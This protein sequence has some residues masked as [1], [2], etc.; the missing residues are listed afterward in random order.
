MSSRPYKTPPIRCRAPCITRGLSTAWRIGRPPSI[1]CP[2]HRLPHIFAAQVGP[3]AAA[4]RVSI[5]TRGVGTVRGRQAVLAAMATLTV[6]AAASWL[7]ATADRLAV[8]EADLAR[9]ALTPPATSPAVE[10][11]ALGATAS[12]LFALADAVQ[13]QGDAAATAFARAWGYLSPSW[14][15]STG[16]AAFVRSWSSVRQLQV[17]AVLPAGAGS[18]PGTARTFAEVRCWQLIGERPAVVFRYAFFTAAPGTAGYQ[19]TAA[20][21]VD[22]QPP[23]MVSTPSPEEVALQTVRVPGERW[24]AGQAQ[25]GTAPHTVQVALSDQ[26][27]HRVLTVVLYQLVNGQWVVLRRLP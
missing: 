20:R 13:R 18:E 4:W 19:L 7:P 1:S 24:Q 3:A 8:A 15:Q 25:A 14:R 22:E 2:L 12:Y 11:S 27:R 5:G 23:D 9:T 26:S 10:A 21:W 17:L 16:F 6:A